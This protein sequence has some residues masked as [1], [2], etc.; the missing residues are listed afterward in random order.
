MRLSLRAGV[1]AGGRCAVLW[2]AKGAGDAVR[3][4]ILAIAG[5]A[6]ALSLSVGAHAASG[7]ACVTSQCEGKGR[8]CVEALYVTHEACMKA[9]N[10]KC[11]TV[12]LA[13]K[14]NCLRG[15]LSPCAQARNAAQDACLADVRQCYRSCGPLPGKRADFWCVGSLGNTT[16][17]AFC[18]TTPGSASIAQQ[19]SKVLSEDAAAAV[20]MTCES[21]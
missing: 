14:F 2:I 16:L 7:V 3:Y 8:T 6:L 4:A 12:A 20:S 21:L 17:A 11:A 15:E 18:A 5:A 13:E 9:G 1:T 19:C 10:A